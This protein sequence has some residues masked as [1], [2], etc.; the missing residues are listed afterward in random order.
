M[1]FLISNA[2]QPPSESSAVRV[3]SALRRCHQQAL[4]QCLEVKPTIEAV[5]ESTETLRC[6]LS[7]AKAVVT[8]TQTGLEVSQHRVDPLQL[9][10]IACSGRTA[11][12]GSLNRLGT[13]RP[14]SKNDSPTNRPQTI[15]RT[16][17]SRIGTAQARRDSGRNRM[18]WLTRG[19]DQPC[20]R[21]CRR[22]AVWIQRSGIPT[23]SPES[24]TKPE[25]TEELLQIARSQRIRKLWIDY[26]R[27]GGR[28]T[29]PK[30]TEP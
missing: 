2:P 18:D 20:S 30:A 24:L 14:S 28:N 21:C 26:A 9:G 23:K 4:G 5:G 25:L 19:I 16:W 1:A 13:W 8:V 15:C 22:L 27:G 17:N 29:E 10:H 7:E 12:S 11:L 6:T 3:R